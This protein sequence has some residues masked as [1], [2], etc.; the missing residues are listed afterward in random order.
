LYACM[1]L[2]LDEKFLMVRND[3]LPIFP[4]PSKLSSMSYTYHTYVLIYSRWHLNIIKI[5]FG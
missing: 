1:H 4:F 3:V 2:V 5:E